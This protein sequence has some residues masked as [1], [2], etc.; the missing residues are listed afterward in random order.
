MDQLRDLVTA[1]V[2]QRLQLLDFLFERGHL[3]IMGLL[4]LLSLEFQTLDFGGFFSD[5]GLEALDLGDQCC[6]L[7]LE[8]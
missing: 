5:D 4:G 1:R 7:L 8:L 2:V 3:F 6:V